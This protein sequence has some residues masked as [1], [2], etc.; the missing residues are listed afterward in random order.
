V[1]ALRSASSGPP[2]DEGASTSARLVELLRKASRG[3][4]TAFAAWYDATATRAFG[5]AVRVLR[6]RAQAEEV[7]QES[8]LDCWRT[9][10]RFDPTRGSPMAWLLTIVHRKA[11]DRVRSV[12]ASGRRETTYSQHT[13]G[14]EHDATAEQATASIEAARVRAALDDLTEKQRQAVSLAFLGGYTH[15]EVA[16]MLDLPVGTA[17]TRIRDGLI[18]LRD[19]LGVE[20]VAQT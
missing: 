13:Q 15:T 9:C 18:R 2:D 1:N 12:E 11:V 20:E 7:T 8:Y 5:L 17:K 16:A 4:E 3:D 19:A 10:A 6:D 14:I